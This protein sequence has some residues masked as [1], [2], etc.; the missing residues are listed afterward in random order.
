MCVAQLGKNDISSKDAAQW[1]E[2]LLKTTTG[3]FHSF[4]YFP[5]DIKILGYCLVGS[6]LPHREK[7][8]L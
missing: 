6:V 8:P 4:T 1:L 5:W 3:I 2:S 7:M